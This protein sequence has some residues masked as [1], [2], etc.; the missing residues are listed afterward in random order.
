MLIRSASDRARRVATTPFVSFEGESDQLVDQL[1]VVQTRRRPQHRV[2]GDRREPR[3]GVDLVDQQVAVAGQEQVD[4]GHALGTQRPVDLEGEGPGR[5][6]G[7]VG[8]FG[9]DDRAGDAGGVLVVEVVEVGAGDD[10]A[11]A[12]RPWR[13]VARHSV[14]EDGALE[15]PGVD[16]RF[17]DDDVVEA[18]RL[19]ERGLERAACRR[20]VRR[21]WRS[22]CSPASR[23]RSVRALPGAHRRALAGR[24]PARRAAAR[25][26][27]AG[28]SRG[29]RAPSWPSPCPSPLPSRGPRRRCRA[30]RRSREVPGWCRPRRSGRAGSAARRW[31][32]AAA[33]VV[34]SAPS[35]SVPGPSI[36]MLAGS[37][38]ARPATSSSAA[39]DAWR[40]SPSRVMPTG[41][42]S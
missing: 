16:A 37:S 31:A 35:R 27:G 10:L 32:G 1:A 23:T 17:D 2:H 34:T 39:V 30:P 4:A 36:S 9:G 5:F 8:Q 29:R 40:Q 6:A 25:A 12:A 15:L 24:D 28:R 3:D 21:R 38:F 26:S 41:T 33:V 13:I 19:D 42:T 20:R 11:D 18:E 7:G 14:A 22:P